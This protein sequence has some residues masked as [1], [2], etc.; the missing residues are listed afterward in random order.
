MPT[1]RYGDLDT[2]VDYL[3]KNILNDPNC[4]LFVSATVHQIID[5]M[6]VIDAVEVIRCRDCA[7]WDNKRISVEGQAR[8][9]TGEYAFRVRAGWDFCSKAKRREVA[10]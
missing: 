4:P 2:L 9:I 7:F 1:K 10:P 8:C 3:D 5:L 6:P